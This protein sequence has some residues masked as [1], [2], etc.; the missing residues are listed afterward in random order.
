MTRDDTIKLMSILFVAY[1][2]FYA[3]TDQSGKEAAAN[4]W[5]DMLQE[6]PP[7]AV[8]MAMRQY[9]KESQ[10]P[11]TIADI[12]KRLE[13]IVEQMEFVKLAAKQYQTAL[14]TG[15]IQGHIEGGEESDG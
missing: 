6:Y 1:P 9:I 4:L 3:N 11:P 10:W 14:E 12:Y 15:E 2:K 7:E 5:Y 8:N 13:P